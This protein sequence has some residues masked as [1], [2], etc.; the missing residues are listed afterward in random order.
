MKGLVCLAAVAA[1]LSLI[2]ACNKDSGSG[3]SA[4][5][6]G[7]SDG[8]GVAECD[9]YITKMEACLQKMDTASKT[10]AEPAFKSTREAWKQAASTT[11]GKDGLKAGCKTALDALDKNPMCK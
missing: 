10:A 3:G 7:A 9:S 2:V 1:G 4:G 8:I 5:A 6:A 11:A